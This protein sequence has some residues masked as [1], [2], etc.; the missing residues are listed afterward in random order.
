[1]H[2]SRRRTKAGPNSSYWALCGQVS[3]TKNTMYFEGVKHYKTKLYVFVN[4][5]QC[6]HWATIDMTQ[7]SDYLADGK[8]D[9]RVFIQQWHDAPG[10]KG[11]WIVGN[12]C[13]TY[14]LFI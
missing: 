7:T 5:K 13:L 2:A 9:I 10:N 1:M 8:K 3:W 6:N 11:R 12:V 4:I 14:S